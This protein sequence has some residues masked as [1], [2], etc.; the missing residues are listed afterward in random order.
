[1]KNLNL[2]CLESCGLYK[3]LYNDEE[4]SLRPGNAFRIGTLEFVVE[5]F[6]TGI[7]SDIG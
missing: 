1:M 6:N 3:R 7:V 2:N 4:Y 5:R